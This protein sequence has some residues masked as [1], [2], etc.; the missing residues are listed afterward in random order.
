M[1]E[2]PDLELYTSNLKKKFCNDRIDDVVILRDKKLNV[3]KDEVIAALKGSVLEDIIREGKELWFRFSSGST[4]SVHLML[5]GRFDHVET[6]KNVKYKIALLKFEQS[7]HLVISDQLGWATLTLNPSL[8]NVPDALS[9]AFD[10]GY[11]K[12]KLSK[13]KS[14]LVK[15]F[16]LNQ[17]IVRGIGNAYV[18]EILWDC[19]VSPSSKC[20]S[21]PD[22]AVEDLY[23]S[24]RQVLQNAVQEL[25]RATPSAINGEYRDFLNVHNPNRKLTPSGY[26]IKIE[27]IAS[28]TTYYTDE[29]ILYE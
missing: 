2:L 17:N 29:Q 14:D 13:R 27:Q 12:E 16:L 18:D 15:P 19:K 26:E 6:E 22:K 8:P 7:H 24:I 1:P 9:E 10:L 23:N 25:V 28:K 4:L 11:L 5:K 3:G 20:N 21:L